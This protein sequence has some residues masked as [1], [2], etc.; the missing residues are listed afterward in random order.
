[1]QNTHTYACVGKV[2]LPGIALQSVSSSIHYSVHES[3]MRGGRERESMHRFN[4]KNK[5][6]VISLL[7]LRCNCLIA[8][9]I[10]H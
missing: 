6:N 9:F 10:V 2:G 4:N 3:C 7:P 5:I 1:M 8:E